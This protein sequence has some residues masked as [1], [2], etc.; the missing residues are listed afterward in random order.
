LKG[1]SSSTGA[2]TFS[3]GPP[4][5]VVYVLGSPFYLPSRY[6]C[7]GPLGRG[8]YGVVRS[9]ASLSWRTRRV[10]RGARGHTLPL[11]HPLTLPP[12]LHS[13]TAG[14]RCARSRDG[15]KSGD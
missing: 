10:P 7:L 4:Y 11:P 9:S 15:P 12:T 8:A 3:S 5:K 2:P 1:S 13:F 6:S 14:L